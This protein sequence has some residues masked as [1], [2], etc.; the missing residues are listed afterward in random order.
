ML[1]RTTGQTEQSDFSD[2]GPVPGTGNPTAP[3]Q[4]RE[5]PFNSIEIPQISLPQ[6]GGAIQG[7]GEKFTANPV[8][9]TG[10]MAVPIAMSPGRGGFGPQLALSYDSGA[11]NGPFGMGWSVGIASIR[12]KTDKG[13]P[14]YDDESESDT[15]ILSGAG[16][17]VPVL[18]EVDGSWQREIVEDEAYTSAYT[19]FRY[20]PRTEGLFARIERWVGSSRGDVHWRVITGDNL[21]TIYGMSSTAR[22]Y[23]SEDEEKA[24][25]FQWLIEKVYDDKGNVLMYEYEQEK[26][27]NIDLR[28]PQEQHRAGEG[29]TF[30]Q[31]YLSRIL[32]G[33][34]IPYR[35]KAIGFDD[36]E[37]QSDNRWHFQL[38]F[39]YG[40]SDPKST[41]TSSP[42]EWPVR[43]DP[44][45]TYRAGFEIRTY[46]LC[47]RI[48]MYHQ[49]DALGA[50][51]YLVRSTELEYSD[52]PVATQLK[53]VT[54]WSHEHEAAHAPLPPVSFKY[55]RAEIDTDIYT[56][57]R[58]EIDTLPLGGESRWYDLEG[59]GLTGI[60]TQYDGAWYYQRNLGDGHFG[61]TE[62][63]AS[64]PSVAQAGNPTQQLVDLASNGRPDLVVMSPGLSG[65]YELDE[66]NE[67]APFVSFQQSPNMSPAD[68][69]VRMLDITGD[70]FPDL[71]MTEDDCFVWN[72]SKAKEGY[73][74]AQRIG[75][76][77]DETLGPAIVFA[78]R[79]Q[80]VFLADMSGDGLTDIVRIRNGEVVYWPNTGYGT[81]GA[82]VTMDNAPH[83]GEPDLFNP[84]R[85]R[86]AD[87]D[88]SGTIDVLYLG[89]NNL[90]FWHNYAGNGWSEQQKIAH[91]PKVDNIASVDTVDLLGNGTACIAW[92]SPL[93]GDREHPIQYIPL[94]SQLKPYLLYEVNN[95]MGAVTRM[96]YAAS[97][98]YY[99]EDRKNGTP[100]ITR[101][102]FPVHVVERVEVHDEASNNRFVSRYAYHHGY[103]DDVERE[104]RG[105]GMVEQ[106]DT[107]DYDSFL[108]HSE[109]DKA[110]TNWSEETD[111]PPV[112][113]KTWFHTGFYDPEGRISRQYEEEYYQGDPEA[114]LLPDT[115]MPA[116]VPAE[117][118]REA[119]RALRGRP[120]RQEVYAIEQ[121]ETKN[122]HP[123]IVSE[124][125]YFIRREQ[126][127]GTNPY[128][129]FYV[130]DCES[131]SYHY[132]REPADPRIAHTHTLEIDRY[133]SVTKAASIVYPR[134]EAYA[135]SDEQRSMY[136][137][138]TESEPL[139][140]DDTSFVYRTGLPGESRSFELRNV[141]PTQLP[142]GKA[143]L[144]GKIPE[145]TT[146]Q[147]EVESEAPNKRLL[148]HS[149]VLYYDDDLKGVLPFRSVNQLAIPYETYTLFFTQSV[150]DQAELDG[151]ITPALL[152][153]GGFKSNVSVFPGEDADESWWAPSGRSLFHP[154]EDYPGG[155]DW[156]AQSRKPEERFYTPLGVRD[157][158]GAETYALQDKHYLLPHRI[159]GPLGNEV[160]VDK[161][162]YRV[163]TPCRMTDANGNRSEVAFDTRGQ[164]IA[165]AIW[166]KEG[167]GDSLEGYFAGFADEASDRLQAILE[168]SHTFLGKATGFFYYD[169]FSWMR[170]REEAKPIPN[171]AA[172]LTREVHVSD[173][174]GVPSPIQRAVSYSDGFGRT[175]LT[176]V[177]A[178]DGE[179][180]LYNEAGELQIGEDGSVLTEGID[181]CTTDQ[182][183]PE[184]PEITRWVGNG[185]VI[186]NNK[187]LPVRQYEP[188]FDSHPYFTD[189]A[190]LR[191]IGVSPWLYYDPLGRNV[192]THFPDGTLTE[193]EFT[194][195]KIVTYDP[196][197]TVLKSAWYQDRMAGHGFTEREI[198]AAEKAALHAD[199]PSIQHLD[200]LGRPW[201]SIAHNKFVYPDSPK[202]DETITGEQFIPTHSF[203]DIQGNIL[204]IRDGRNSEELTESDAAID[205]NLRTPK[206]NQT[207]Q[208]NR[209]MTYAYAM[210]GLQLYQDS[211]DAGRRWALVNALGNP[212]YSWDDRGHASR[213][214]YD[215]L[216]RPT[217][218]FVEPEGKEPIL[219]ERMFYGEDIGVI[220][221]ARKFNLRG[222]LIWHFDGAGLLVNQRMDFKGNPLESYRRLAQFDYK[223]DTTKPSWFDTVPTWNSFGESTFLPGEEE[224]I[225]RLETDRYVTTSQYDALNRPVIMTAPDGYDD[226]DPSVY[227]YGYNKAGALNDLHVH[228]QGDPGETTFVRNIDYNA[229]GQR[230]CI[231]YGNGVKTTYRYDPNTFRLK[232]LLSTRQN[233]RERVQELKYVYDPVGNITYLS[234]EAQDVIFNGGE[235]RPDHVYH[236]DSLYRLIAATGREHKTNNSSPMPDGYG[237]K[238]GSPS[239]EDLREYSQSY[240]YDPVGNID[241]M[242]HSANSNG[243]W[244]RQYHYAPNNNRLLYHH[245]GNDEVEAYQRF[246]YDD[247]GSMTTMPHLETLTWDYKDQLVHVNRIESGDGTYFYTYDSNRQRVRKVIFEG[248]LCKER[249]YLGAFEL[250]RECYA[251]DKAKNVHHTLHVMDDTSR[252][253]SIDRTI[254][255]ALPWK[256][257][258]I[259]LLV[260]FQLSNHLGSAT[261]EMEGDEDATLVSYE[262]YHPYGT[263]AYRTH[264][265]DVEASLKRYRYTGMERDEETG[266]NYHTARYYAP[267][268]GR[269]GS[270]DPTGLEGGPHLYEYSLANPINYKDDNGAQPGL[271][272]LSAG[273]RTIV[274]PSDL[275]QEDILQGIRERNKN[276][277]EELGSLAGRLRYLVGQ[278]QADWSSISAR[279]RPLEDRFR[280]V[281]GD[282][283]SIE[284]KPNELERAIDA[285]LI[286]AEVDEEG[287]IS[288]YE[289]SFYTPGR[290]DGDPIDILS[291]QLPDFKKHFEAAEEKAFD[292]GFTGDLIG[293]ITAVI[294]AVFLIGSLGAGSI[295]RRAITSILRKS[296][297]GVRRA[298]GIARA[299][300]RRFR[301]FPSQEGWKSI[302]LGEATSQEL[303]L[304][305]EVL[306]AESVSIGRTAGGSGHLHAAV[307]ADG[308][309]TLILDNWLDARGIQWTQRWQDVFNRALHDRAAITRQP[310]RVMSGGPYTLGEA[311]AAEAGARASG[312]T[313]IP[314]WPGN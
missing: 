200:T 289:I 215:A 266:L 253:C 41:S 112:L 205:F 59:E 96:Q 178:E 161:H 135:V 255:G 18:H 271:A 170:T 67:W 183:D 169:P 296:V 251:N 288:S 110:P 53:S 257:V 21:T 61:D 14:Q 141:T 104:F 155:E 310:V 309:P 93:P 5:S 99:L 57:S 198:Q 54:H 111:I 254:K 174:N 284:Y 244:T 199:T 108:E 256:K 43:S 65:F 85:I 83:F 164:V 107:E 307:R 167:E 306:N 95:N 100:W 283:G 126:G 124:N 68:P 280:R 1:N 25:I 56:I 105:F 211:M 219:V 238:T 154:G 150:L 221:E 70:G 235:I 246:T 22:I 182:D 193:V 38:V 117:E 71:V 247:H 82:R 119:V 291:A 137:T 181:Y 98:R 274:N 50:E 278:N 281:T 196:N 202:I 191:E 147:G 261:M 17:L 222:Q 45:S 229:R 201:V 287:R 212:F 214:K 157:I 237:Y 302:R 66:E 7:I 250:Y 269:W 8:T 270:A 86:L 304:W 179:R 285:G 58:D 186:Y 162:N 206:G 294:E 15:F 207:S 273:R 218:I 165:S 226:L 233:G 166:G 230:S 130:C 194:P 187:G 145:I 292:G 314:S 39:D 134:R 185:R 308:R 290:N 132:E 156:D 295:L 87:I 263:S 44:F 148:S 195:W 268:L 220:E 118:E 101:L 216:Q 168:D 301:R 79:F 143:D 128:A 243:G 293:G 260:R 245:N 131:L 146:F 213:V 252:I 103:F 116:D 153:Q 277:A 151:K 127:R 175:M 311:R 106:W 297:N 203:Q 35:M 177:Q 279:V 16:D 55:T 312:I 192:C 121:Y 190:A 227:R 52:H 34:S 208:G 140:Q 138:C 267:W 91:F 275:S 122:A 136:I 228:V 20:R 240:F 62:V 163:L 9:G 29:R 265:N 33:N 10:S 234:D 6:G 241:R 171:Y 209:V 27:Q 12:R 152:L 23:D 46:R 94:M 49:F 32:Y 48:L 248:G 286:T 300:S 123:Y 225:E 305:E 189:N 142:W 81:F 129:V 19:V 24:R 159:R 74:P 158:F 113:T 224:L 28:L 231:R 223:K 3:S 120:L 236:Y 72:A 149:R 144:S 63:V 26:G 88:G 259:E 172:G 75:K 90:Y 160:I 298:T 276:F 13:I 37:W 89:T 64:I 176:K 173:E 84:G 125:K 210:N 76:V 4:E 51:P 242:R 102:P 114:W 36:P 11:G 77:L 69:N 197:D 30:A 282:T 272:H 73:A 313:N 303:A 92:T 80:S 239:K 299:L 139:Y 180:P 115:D 188:F 133:G 47:R 2:R 249:I 258:S 97:T 184:T 264:R 109:F 60:L 40:D 31:R 232:K 217:H 262:E 78:E 42:D 204:E